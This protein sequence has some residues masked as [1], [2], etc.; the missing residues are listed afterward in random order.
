MCFATALD[1][2]FENL[3]WMS[4]TKAFADLQATVDGISTA[5]RA[6]GARKSID[7]IKALTG[8]YRAS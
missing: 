5:I 4:A 1:K 3:D 7:E 6:G 8:K 2:V